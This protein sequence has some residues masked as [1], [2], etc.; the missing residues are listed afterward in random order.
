MQALQNIQLPDRQ[1][2]IKESRFKGS[3]NIEEDLKAKDRCSHRGK[4][5]LWGLHF[6][7]LHRLT[8][9]ATIV[10]LGDY[11]LK[12]EAMEPRNW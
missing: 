3:W 10:V 4:L 5:K 12:V 6:C 2:G 11:D 7:L 1:L 8:D 9:E